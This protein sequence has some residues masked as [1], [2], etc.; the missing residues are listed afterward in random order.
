MLDSSIY[1]FVMLCHCLRDKVTIQ[2]RNLRGGALDYGPPAAPRRLHRGGFCC[3]CKMAFFAHLRSSLG[4][5]LAL[6]ARPSIWFTFAKIT[7]RKDQLLSGLLHTPLLLLPVFRSLPHHN[8]TKT[9]ISMF[10]ETS[11][12]LRCSTETHGPPRISLTSIFG[13]SSHPRWPEWL[14]PFPGGTSVLCPWPRAG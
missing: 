5:Q 11:A 9:L 6:I 12:H 10:A 7:P 4:W 3:F 2:H 14:W 8:S 13:A 1:H